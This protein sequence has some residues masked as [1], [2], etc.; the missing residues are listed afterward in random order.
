MKSIK[1]VFGFAIVA[2]IAAIGCFFVFIFVPQ[3]EI[4]TLEARA[5]EPVLEN[6]LL[7]EKA[8]EESDL[9]EEAQAEVL[10]F[11]DTYKM[12]IE[13]EDMLEQLYVRRDY[14]EKYGISYDMEDIFT[15][16]E[17]NIEEGDI[18][19]DVYLENIEKIQEYIKLYNIDESRYA[20]MT[21]EEEL[22]TLEV[23]YGLLPIQELAE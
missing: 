17:T 15:L 11:R 13:L 21:V 3:K 10:R 5:I 4:K 1:L 12:E 14:E 20:S 18:G 7:L 22:A 16:E 23:E 8:T 19:S 6:E 9:L 2:L